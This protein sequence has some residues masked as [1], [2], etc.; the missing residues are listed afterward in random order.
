MTVHL[1]TVTLLVLK[2]DKYLPKLPG[3]TWMLT[4]CSALQSLQ[5]KY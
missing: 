5:E 1:T 3:V 4:V 2:E